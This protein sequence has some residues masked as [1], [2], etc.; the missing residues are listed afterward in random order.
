MMQV[1]VNFFVF[2]FGFICGF[3]SP[4]SFS[5]L[6]I[7][8]PYCLSKFQL[9]RVIAGEFCPLC[10]EGPWYF[11]CAKVAKSLVPL[12]GTR[13]NGFFGSSFTFLFL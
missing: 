11:D 8:G 13:M 3:I 6:M 7:E 5:L 12:L 1:L 4:Y 10:Y 2:V 9:A